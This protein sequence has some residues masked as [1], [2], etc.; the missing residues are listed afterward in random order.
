[1]G[2]IIKNIN[3]SNRYRYHPFFFFFTKISNKTNTIENFYNKNLGRK[4]VLIMD[5]WDCIFFRIKY[6]D[7]NFKRTY[8]NFLEF[9][10][11]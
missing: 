10:Y 4:F 7:K 5:E 9:N 3:K 8:M 6:Y 1:M 11:K 2:C